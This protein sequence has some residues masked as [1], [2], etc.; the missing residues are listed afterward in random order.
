MDNE[1]VELASI[2]ESP[3]FLL[4]ATGP[5]DERLGCVG[6]R[7]LDPIDAQMS[8]EIRRLF[9]R[10]DGRGQGLGRL[11]TERLIADAARGG[12]ARLVLN[13]LPAMNEAVAL[14]E[15]LGFEPSEP[16]VDEPLDDTLYFAL[17]LT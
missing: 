4:L 10:H 7:T 8:G 5:D 2:Y 11:L 3:G 1:L 15:A 12:F 6:L 9:V 17:D 13:T 16:Y 14:Y